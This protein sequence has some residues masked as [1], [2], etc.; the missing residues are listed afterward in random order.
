MIDLTTILEA[1]IALAV[2]IITAFVIPWFKSKTTAQEREEMLA[3]V[4]IA[5]ASAQQL[6]SNMD[7]EARLNYALMLLESKGYK[8][9]DFVLNSALEAAVLKLHQQLEGAT[10]DG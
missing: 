5:V 2:A 1:T 4:D 3:W 10:N 7:G 9:D 6:F 8:V